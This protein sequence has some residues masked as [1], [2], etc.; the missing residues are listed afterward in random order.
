LP[1]PVHRGGRRVGAV[2]RTA[3]AKRGL[4]AVFASDPLQAV[5][6]VLEAAA[7]PVA[8]AA[9][10]QRLVEE[11]VPATEATRAWDSVRPRLK[12]HEHVVVEGIRYQW[13][14]NGRREL[15]AFE[16]IEL[17][18]EGGLREARRKELADLVRAA[19]GHDQERAAR[20]RRADIDA[21]RA[22]AELASEVEE[23]VVNEASPTALIHRVR[24]RVARSSLEPLSRAGEELTFDRT[25]HRPIGGGIR[26]GA[27][28]VVVRPG[29][30]WRS[31]AGDVLVA[32]VLVEE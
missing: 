12:D 15:S 3:T 20:Q 10:L 25:R 18:A 22:L 24:A 7:A 1:V 21:M 17:L 19:L 28:V 9:I 27:P 29:Y 13:S 16:A 32:E 30:V 6:K 4:P 5:L 8:K 14:P 2:S 26:D 11:G 23:L 31:V